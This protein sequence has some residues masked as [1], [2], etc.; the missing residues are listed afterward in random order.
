MVLQEGIN[1]GPSLVAFCIRND[2]GDLVYA[3][4]QKIAY[5]NN[6]VAED[7]AIKQGIEYCMDY[8][9]HPLLVETDSLAMK[10]FIKGIWEVPWCIS[11]ILKDINRLRRGQIVEV[12]HIYKEG[13]CLTDFLANYVFYFA[14][15]QQF[16]S[17]QE[18]PSMTMRLLNIDKAQIL[19]LRIR[20]ASDTIEYNS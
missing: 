1:P 11:M 17:F 7:V 3:T 2:N 5:G 20:Y 18:L 15:T 9:L 6:L 4:T 19:N 16:T 8:Q 10:M 12:E 13:N 14:G